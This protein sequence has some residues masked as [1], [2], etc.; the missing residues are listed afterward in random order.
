MTSTWSPSKCDKPIGLSGDF[1]NGD[2]KESLRI[3][4]E[5]K[6]IKCQNS[7]PRRPASVGSNDSCCRPAL[8]IRSRSLSADAEGSGNTE[9]G[10]A[11]FCEVIAKTSKDETHAEDGAFFSKKPSDVG[12]LLIIKKQI[13]YRIPIILDIT[14]IDE[15][16]QEKGMRSEHGSTILS[17]DPYEFCVMMKNNGAAELESA[18]KGLFKFCDWV[19]ILS[20]APLPDQVRRDLATPNVSITKTISSVKRPLHSAPTHFTPVPI[21]KTCRSSNA[22]E[23]LSNGRSTNGSTNVQPLEW[24]N[25]EMVGSEGSII[26]LNTF[27]ST[28]GWNSASRFSKAIHTFAH[29]LGKPNSILDAQ[30]RIDIQIKAQSPPNQ[31]RHSISIQGLRLPDTGGSTPQSTPTSSLYFRQH[32]LGAIEATAKMDEVMTQQKSLSER[33]PS[34]VLKSMTKDISFPHVQQPNV[35]QHSSRMRYFPGSS[36]G[37]IQSDMLLASHSMSEAPTFKYKSQPLFSRAITQPAIAL[38][39]MTSR[40]APVQPLPQRPRYSNGG[41]SEQPLNMN[42]AAGIRFN[43]AQTSRTPSKVTSAHTLAP[44]QVIRQQTVSHPQAQLPIG[45]SIACAKCQIFPHYALIGSNQETPID[46]SIKFSEKTSSENLAKQDAVTFNACQSA[47]T[48]NEEDVVIN[49]TRS[50]SPKCAKSYPESS[51]S[52]ASLQRHF[53]PKREALM[54]CLICNLDFE[55]DWWLKKHYRGRKHVC[56]LLESVG[57]SE[58]LQKRIKSREINS[59]TLVNEKTGKLLLHVV[60]R[61]INNNGCTRITKH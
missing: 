23:S 60:N 49:L 61:L 11:H 37:Q 54:K 27:G 45:P 36:K 13:I 17:N 35:I 56:R 53:A 19:K 12:Y 7:L 6:T 5:S 18:L 28:N 50:N 16:R 47:S 22:S 41:N 34:S 26:Q 58:G 25:T 55:M 48:Y 9:L 46:L 8:T 21:K 20:A 43:N 51:N 39:E 38:A 59:E 57:G 52:E 4:G 42:V 30:D 33:N 1:V 2:A 31:F 10:K 3:N 40:M 15:S 44:N 24:M 14:R 29:D 32:S